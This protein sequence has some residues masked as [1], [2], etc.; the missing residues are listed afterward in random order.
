MTYRLDS[1]IPCPFIIVKNKTG[2]VIGPKNEMIWKTNAPFR[3]E[4]NPD[5]TT[6]RR[7]AAWFPTDCTRLSTPSIF[8]F[9]LKETLTK[10]KLDVDTYGNCGPLVCV[11]GNRECAFIN[12]NYFFLL[13]LENNEAM[14]YVTDKVLIALQ[15]NVVPV[16]YGGADY[17]RFL[18]PGSFIDG[19]KLTAED[20]AF[21][22]VSSMVRHD[23]YQ[24][25][26]TWKEHYSFHKADPIIN[27]CSLCEALD[28]EANTRKKKVYRRF[29]RWWNPDYTEK[30]FIEKKKYG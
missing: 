7:L 4:F 12:R 25:Y 28:D 15:N 18:P 26:F 8:T 21:R 13:V 1:D 27:L 14:D 20:I 19:S 29:R 22:M 6:K 17:S 10:Y 2:Y 16:V 11:K 24:K 30:C 23:L 3:Q 9:M 5:I